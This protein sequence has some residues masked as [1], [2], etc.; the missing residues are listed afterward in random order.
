MREIKENARGADMLGNL[1]TQTADSCRAEPDVLRPVTR[2]TLR[3]CSA[4]I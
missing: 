2:R 1:V 4:R 3:P